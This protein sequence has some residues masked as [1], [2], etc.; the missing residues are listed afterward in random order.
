MKDAKPRKKGKIK[1]IVVDQDACVSVSSC[2]AVAPDV[3]QLDEEG[4]AYIVDP[5]SVD[6]D[7]LLLS[8]QSCPLL[9]IHL[10]DDKGNKIFPD[11]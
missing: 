9:A 6:D 5:D 11:N 3:F 7:T 8:A 10:Y 1:K 2:V 4:K